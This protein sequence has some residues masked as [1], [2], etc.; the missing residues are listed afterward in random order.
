[1]YMCYLS[2]D[3]HCN[4]GVTRETENQRWEEDLLFSVYFSVCIKILCC[5]H[6]LPF[7]IRYLR[8]LNI[9]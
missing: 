6:V 2:E 1:M 7:K 4:T 5:V 9:H 3:T 8:Y